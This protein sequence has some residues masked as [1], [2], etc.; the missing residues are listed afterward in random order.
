VQSNKYETGGA[1]LKI[2]CSGFDADKLKSPVAILK[3][4][5]WAFFIP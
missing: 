5:E 3:P 4:K 2:P 1:S